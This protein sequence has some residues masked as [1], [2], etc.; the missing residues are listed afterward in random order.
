MNVV[1]G[2]C[3]EARYLA[4]KGKERIVQF[5][6]GS[7]GQDPHKLIPLARSI[8]YGGTMT[9]AMSWGKETSIPYP[10]KGEGVKWG[11]YL[12]KQCECLLHITESSGKLFFCFLLAFF[13][14]LLP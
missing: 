5:V 6:Y 10:P 3:G 11:E 12:K 8:D 4:G 1:A 9:L 2:M 14:F 7:D 13:S